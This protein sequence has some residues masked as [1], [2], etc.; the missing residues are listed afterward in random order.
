VL[1]ALAKTFPNHVEPDLC[2]PD[3]KIG[4]DFI[5]FMRP[6]QRY[7]CIAFHIVFRYASV[8]K[9]FDANCKEKSLIV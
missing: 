2:D 3:I 8:R 1:G 9:L 5:L 7:K 6:L 4:F